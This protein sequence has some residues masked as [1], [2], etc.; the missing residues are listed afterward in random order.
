MCHSWKR[1]L[2][3]P[4]LIL[5][6]HHAHFHSIYLHLP[7]APWGVFP[8]AWNVAAIFILRPALGLQLWEV[9]TWW[10]HHRS[11]AEKSRPLNLAKMRWIL[12][13]PTNPLFHLNLSLCHHVDSSTAPSKPRNVPFCFRQKSNG[14]KRFDFCSLPLVQQMAPCTLGP[15]WNSN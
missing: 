8:L 4:T 10:P 3:M 9:S 1:Q 2:F 7:T 11:K 15:I 13:N 14:T 5:C 6:L 12:F